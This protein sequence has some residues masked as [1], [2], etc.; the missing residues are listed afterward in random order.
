MAPGAIDTEFGG[1]KDAN[2]KKQLSEMTALGK[3]GEAED[4]GPFV[5]GLLTDDSGFLNAQRI[6]LSGGFYI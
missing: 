3:I 5:A 4:I 1:G 2:M 6:E